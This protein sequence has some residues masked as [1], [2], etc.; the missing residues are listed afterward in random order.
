MATYVS[1]IRYTDQGIRNVK[2][3]P[4]RL[5]AAKKAFQGA[6][7]EL[8]QFFLAMGEYDIVMIS[9]APND[10]TVAT[11]ALSLGSLG[12]VRTETMRVFTESEYRKIIGSI[13]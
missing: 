6:G 12:N 13:R 1:L 8:K 2:E 9:E 10:E 3:S 11:I 7:G 4:A 5:D